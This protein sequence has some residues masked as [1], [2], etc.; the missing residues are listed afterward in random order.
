[1]IIYLSGDCHGQVESFASRVEQTAK[2]TDTS[3]DWVICLGNFGAW[4]DP[5]QVDR[6]TR[7][8]GKTDFHL[9]YHQQKYLPFKTLFIP[10]R[11][12][13]HRWISSMWSR[14]YDEFFP[15]FFYLPNGYKK[16]LQANEEVMTLVGLGRVYSP[17]SYTGE[18]KAWHYSKSEV[19]RACS[20][21]PVD[22]FVSTEAGHGVQ[23]G[24]VQSESEGI[25]KIDFATRPKLA[26]HAHYNTS[27]YYINPYTQTPTLSLAYRQIVALEFSGKFRF[28]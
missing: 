28:V 26:A 16:A 24:T 8:A 14:G 25:N 12:E 1:M 15:N 21:G 7:K 5:K 10:G 20:Q 22:L 13:D 6:N 3:P 18:R 11:N 17:N 4:P 2:S 9:Y 19:E 23:V 27:E